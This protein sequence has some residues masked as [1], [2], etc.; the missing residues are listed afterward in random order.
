MEKVSLDPCTK[1]TKNLS[2]VLCTTLAGKVSDPWTKKIDGIPW[3][4]LSD[5]GLLVLRENVSMEPWIAV[6]KVLSLGPG[7]VPAGS[8][9]VPCTS[10]AGVGIL[11]DAAS[12]SNVELLEGASLT[13][14]ERLP[15]GRG[16]MDWTDDACTDDSAGPTSLMG[17]SLAEIWTPGREDCALAEASVAGRLDDSLAA[18]SV[19]GSSDLEAIN[20]VRK[21]QLDTVFKVEPVK[22][23]YC[24][25]LQDALPSSH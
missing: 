21:G 5:G 19:K 4:S 13:C 1:V 23:V 6:T 11:L 24:N 25:L 3:L 7:M 8:V 18:L 12:D 17:D 10:T 16:F 20:D 2:L 14:S 22:C 9:C 15:E